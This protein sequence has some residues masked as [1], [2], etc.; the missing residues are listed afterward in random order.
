[1]QRRL[2]NIFPNRV[3]EIVNLGLTAVNSYTLLD[4]TDELLQQKPDAVLI[5]A[6]HNEYYGALGVAS[7]ENGSIPSWLKKLH[8]KLIH[9]R[10]YQLLQKGIGSIYK[11]MHPV[12]KDE[13]KET[14]MERMVGRNLIPYNSKM[15][16]E[17][18]MQ[19]SDNM[20]HVLG[21][22]K[23]AHVP[24]IISD[25]VSNIRDL[26]PF[27]SLQYE[28]YPRADS[29]FFDAK[30]LEAGHLF[31]KAKEEYIRAKDYDVI[32]FRASEDFNKTI[33]KLADSLGLYHISLKSLFEKY[34]PQG[35]IGNNLM[36][37]HLH[38]N[39]DGYFLMA[40]GFL[41]ALKDLGMIENYWDSTRV[42]PWTYYRHNWGFTELDSTI[43][44]IRIKQ[45]KAGWPFQ[46]EATVNNFRTTYTPHGIID[47]IA[48]LRVQYDNV[49]TEMVHKRLAE[50]Y[51]SLGDFKRASKEYLSI[52]YITPSNALAFYYAADFAQKAQD[53][54]NAIRYLRESPN[55][56][57]SSYAQ[58]ALASIYYSQKNNKEALTCIDRMQ[59]LRSNVIN[60]LKVQKLKYNVL[61]ASG[62]S[63]DAEK[64]LA[65][66]KKMDP[67]FNESEGGKS[68]VILIPNRI[69]PYLEKAET[70]RKNGQLSE[71]L[72]V[73]KEAN[74]IREL[75]YTNLLIGKLLFTQK[76]VEA[77]HYL[78][79]AHRE[80]KDDPSLI[81]CLCVLYIVK[82]DIPKAK[83]AINDFARLKGKNYPQTEQL[84]S[85]FEKAVAGKK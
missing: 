10:T 9:I 24:V 2:Q 65:E 32:R 78:E 31:N 8:L 84:R 57:T 42:R 63:S 26:P 75:S 47:S 49:S 58:F 44:V 52:A 25:L 51:E 59:R 68:L 34:S 21:K 35:I 30:R 82:R 85:W 11:L 28:M 64:T 50:Y 15:Y 20:T 79:K 33:E 40:E 71:A 3:I 13:A 55:P 80:I 45:L 36:T 38:P 16:S 73:L 39:V 23:E 54:T 62:L 61:K 74:T 53:T 6:G 69:K 83:E 72:S 29:L 67:S 43:A 77:L 66:I 19:F 17:G 76:K 7:M 70:L 48:F 1:M 81:Y 46:P 56:D 37:D 4:F 22:L 18:L 5:Y 12:T 14:M 60:Y 27:R 41:D